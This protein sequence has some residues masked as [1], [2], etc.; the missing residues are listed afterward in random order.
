MEYRPNMLIPPD[1]PAA[2]LHSRGVTLLELVAG[3][4][5]ITLF[6]GMAFPHFDHFR[7]SFNRMNVRQTVLQDLRRAQSESM[8]KGCRGIFSIS[9]DQHSYSFGCDYL[10]FNPS[11][12]PVADDMIFQRLLPDHIY[13]S[14]DA[15]IIFNSQ[16]QI[17]DK[18]SSAASR[19]VTLADDM[20]SKLH[21]FSSG[22][23]S[24]NGAFEFN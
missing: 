14:S 13:I 10:D 9:S 2:P 16:G 18:E 1:E 23:L 7:N 5:C 8:S 3:L 19:I 6:A 22:V 15:L 17:V 24:Q 12:H 4:F 11:A 20:D 21:A